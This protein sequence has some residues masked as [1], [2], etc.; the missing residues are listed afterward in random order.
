MARVVTQPEALRSL[1]KLGFEISKGGRH[2]KS[3]LI[4]DGRK[5]AVTVLPKSKGEIPRGTAH[6]FRAQLHLNREQFDRAI[7][8]P[9]KAPEYIDI[10]DK[11]GLL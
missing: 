5:V 7:S 8:C 10:L 11:H 1:K 2:I 3:T 6:A 9:L 4:V